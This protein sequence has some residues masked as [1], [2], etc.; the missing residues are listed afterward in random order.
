LLNLASRIPR[1]RRPDDTREHILRLF[2][3]FTIT[4][5]T[6]ALII[7]K[8]QNRLNK[9]T[10]EELISLKSLDIYTEEK[11]IK[12]K[13]LKNLRYLKRIYKRAE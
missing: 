4:N 5:N 6:G 1:I 9:E 12:L 7:S 3:A 10:F 2:F 11:D 13:E 8:L